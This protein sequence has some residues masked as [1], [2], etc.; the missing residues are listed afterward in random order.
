MWALLSSL[1]ICFLVGYIIY[2]MKKVFVQLRAYSLRNSEQVS[3]INHI[4]NDSVQ[5]DR[6][7]DDD[8]IID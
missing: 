5:N 4:Q 2:I 7:E 6:D 8:N 3:L 1:L